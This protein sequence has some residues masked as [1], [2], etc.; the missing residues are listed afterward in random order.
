MYD[1]DVKMGLVEGRE[2]I[3]ERSAIKRVLVVWSCES[4]QPATVGHL[5]REF[6]TDSRPIEE[7]VTVIQGRWVAS[8]ASIDSP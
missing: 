6:P 2:E 1:H 8:P 4:G 5:Q 3:Q 7:G